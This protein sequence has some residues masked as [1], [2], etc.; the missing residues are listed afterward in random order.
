MDKKLAD[1][2]PL[3]RFLKPSYFARTKREMKSRAFDPYPRGEVSVYRIANL[4][5][6]EIW[7]IADN[8]VVPHSNDFKGICEARG[9]FSTKA[10]R[11]GGLDVIP[12]TKIHD[13]HANIVNWDPDPSTI[14][15]EKRDEV[16]QKWHEALVEIMATY[17]FHLR[18]DL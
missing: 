1:T 9:D 10:V 17:E 13:L 2:E 3:T 16:K 6:K 12:D 15:K 7:S 11:A 18:D 4:D 8:Y 14:S 5:N